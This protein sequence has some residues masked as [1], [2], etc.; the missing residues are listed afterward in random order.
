[1]AGNNGTK[2]R[3]LGEDATRKRGDCAVEAGSRAPKGRRPSRGEVVRDPKGKK[4]NARCRGGGALPRQW[5]GGGKGGRHPR[6]RGNEVVED[7][8]SNV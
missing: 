6:C 2:A 7:W 8:G 5:K 3:A 4:S 1:M